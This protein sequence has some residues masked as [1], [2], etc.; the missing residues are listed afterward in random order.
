[1]ILLWL[2]PGIGLPTLI[3]WLAVRLLESTT[4]V[5]Q[6]GERWIIGFVLGMTLTMT[7]VFY[8]HALTGIPL[9][10]WGFL[11][12]VLVLLGLLI[13]LTRLLPIAS[14][15]RPILRPSHT[16]LPRWLWI[17]IIVL[18][19]WTVVKILAAGTTFLLLTPPAL[20]DVVDNWNL[21]GKMFFVEQRIVLQ[22]PDFH[23]VL[24]SGDVSAYPPTIPLVKTWL[25]ALSG[26]WNE[27]LINS[28]HLLWYLAALALLFCILR[29]LMTLPWALLGV[30]LL[31]SLPLYLMHG[32]NPYADVCLSVHLF[33][34]VGLLYLGI[35]STEQ[36]E[37]ESF[38]RL[39]AFATALLSLL[40]N[41][42]LVMH[43]PILFLVLI[44]ALW[45][46]RGQMNGRSAVR[47]LTWYAGLFLA[48]VLPWIVYK[49][50]HGLAFGNAKALTQMPIAWQPDVLRSIA[51]NTFLEGNWLLLPL[52]LISLLFL[53]WRTAFRTPLFVISAFTLLVYSVQFPL[54][55]FTPLSTEAV[56]QTGYARGL[57]QLM[58]LLVFMV[59]VLITQ[60][61]SKTRGAELPS[62]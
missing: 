42:A 45:K 11:T 57:I 40:K 44:V 21:R 17:T 50:S 6:R 25:A 18:G 32:T 26:T 36:R 60:V 34:A 15:P 52:L 62:T 55:M 47:I 37:R 9:S 61:F 46:Y 38:L 13:G 31:A 43:L 14:M 56:N 19:T 33:I 49:W 20:D 39:S 24:Q 27:G 53:Q 2:I 16:P 23:G 54:F 5:L 30:Y 35:R 51:I 3:G 8:T 10:R 48:I 12:I 58:P 7:V 41:E 1:M 4:P 28:V 29:R 59:T 22:T